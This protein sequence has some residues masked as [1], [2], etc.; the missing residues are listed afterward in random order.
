MSKVLNLC[1]ARNSHAS[2]M[3]EALILLEAAQH[4]NFAPHP[5][6][7]F[8]SFEL[9]QLDETLVTLRYGEVIHR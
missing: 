7:M 1:E 4:A 3:S 5:S 9:K 6:Q 8:L 2:E